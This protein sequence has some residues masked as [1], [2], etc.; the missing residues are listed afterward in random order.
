MILMKNYRF[1]KVNLLVVIILFLSYSFVGCRESKLVTQESVLNKKSTPDESSFVQ[2]PTQTTSWSSINETTYILD[3]EECKIP[4]WKGVNPGKTS[5]D[6]LKDILPGG[7]YYPPKENRINNGKSI[8][9][10]DYRSDKGFVTS[11]ILLDNTVETLFFGTKLISLGSCLKRLGD[12]SFVV[13]PDIIPEGGYEIVDFFFPKEGVRIEASGGIT[14]HSDNIFQ[15]HP[16]MIVSN[17]TFHQVL[18]SADFQDILN[19]WF[20]YDDHFLREFYILFPWQGY[21][22]YEIGLE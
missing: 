10:F 7:N 20:W 2:T 18:E 8:A 21:G 4:C 11:M 13:I 6:E 5:L 17:I 16:G 12:P 15:V 9:G 14:N 22:D 19:E 1:L 3:D